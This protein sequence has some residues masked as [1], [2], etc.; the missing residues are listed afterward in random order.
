MSFFE[1]YFLNPILSNGWFNPVNT[2][3]YAIGLIVGVWL[4]FRLLKRLAVPIDRKF[5]YALFPFIV[6]GSSTRVL[7]DAAVARALPAGLQ[8]FYSLPFFPTPGSYFITFGVALAALVASLLV[9]RYAKLPYWKTMVGVGGVLALANLAMTPWRFAEP[10]LLIGGLW[11][12]WMALFWGVARLLKAQ[13]VAARV[14][15]LRGLLGSVNLAILGGHLLDAAGTYIALARYG[16]L[17]QHVVPRLLFEA[18]GPASFFALKIAV[19]VP[20][21]FLVDRYGEK[22]AFQ[23]LLKIVIFILGFAPGLRTVLR[24]AAGV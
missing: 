3:V 8:E 23:S 20:V 1:E 6:W 11:A 5:A 14:P 15:A 10:V 24:L 17:E 2:S 4:V 13:R 7:H 9:Q 21:L 22:G 19:V 18:M 16:Y 12:A